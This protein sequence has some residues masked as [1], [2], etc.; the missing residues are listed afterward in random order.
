MPG[1]VLIIRNVPRENPGLIE[2]I[3]NQENIDFKVVDFEDNSRFPVLDRLRAVIVLG[4]PESAND[5]TPKMLN[6]LAFI[7]SVI[8]A[9]IPFL[10]ICLGLQTL[11][12][13]MGGS[14]LR[15]RIPET[16]F[17]DNKGDL[18]RVKLTAEG[19][20]DSL[21][22]GLPGEFVVFQLHG[23]TVLLSPEMSLLGTGDNCM[24]QII[25]IGKNAYGFQFHFEL[26]DDLLKS[27]MSEDADLQKADHDMLLND[28]RLLKADYHKTGGLIIANFLAISGKSDN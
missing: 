7:R 8:E 20:A 17:R 21:L 24:N 28:Y 18:Y 16:G 5:K 4:G 11:V 12:K 25:R 2:V 22:A 19:E 1:E 23:E 14:V 13:S 6:E 26:T 27:W 10:G 15:C 3:L 9:G